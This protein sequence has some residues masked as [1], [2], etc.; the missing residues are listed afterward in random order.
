MTNNGCWSA[1]LCNAP[2]FFVR[3]HNLASPNTNN[4]TME[5]RTTLCLRA[6]Y[7]EAAAGRLLLLGAAANTDSSNDS[8]ASTVRPGNNDG[9]GNAATSSPGSRCP[10]CRRYTQLPTTKEGVLLTIYDGYKC[11]IVPQNFCGMGEA[12]FGRSPF[13]IHHSKPEADLIC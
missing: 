7:A 3:L 13:F 6:T 9:D 4:M 12:K 1:L 5:F 11:Q 8:N 2:L 10:M